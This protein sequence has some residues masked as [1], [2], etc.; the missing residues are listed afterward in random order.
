[1]LIKKIELLKEVS[2]YQTSELSLSRKQGAFFE[3]QIDG[4]ILKTD[5]TTLSISI[6]KESL[7]VLV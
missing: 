6:K 4:E 1:M 5:D 2:Y 3:S 7:S